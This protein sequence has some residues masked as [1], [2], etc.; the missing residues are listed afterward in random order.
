M[1]TR[2]IA[3]AVL[4]PVLLVLLLAAPKIVTAVIW[5][6]L[7]AVG[8]YELLYRT[9]LVREARLVIYSAV[10][11]FAIAMWSFWD[12]V[13]AWGMIGLML[14]IMLLFAEMMMSHVKITFDKICMCL[15]AGVLVPLLLSSLIRIHTMK[16][17]KFMVLIPFIVAFASDSGAY[18][19]GRYFGAHK[20]APVISPHKTVEGAVGGV[21]CAVLCMIIYAV[22]LD[23]PVELFNFNVNYLY[24]A[25]YGLLGSLVG[26][27]GDLCFSVIK[28]QTGI[29][30]YGNLIPG[31]GGFLDR[32]DSMMLVG[33][34]MEALMLLIPVAV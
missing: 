2:I 6:I 10:M 30:D 14:F 17:G 24:A 18:F 9:D 25:L 28:R 21:I 23:L 3:A 34:L 8:A 12:A 31:H 7:L 16:I 15:V 32:F 1:K 27:V 11:A 4:I 19:A 26:I 5:G 29:K 33:P 13:H 22:V 20:L